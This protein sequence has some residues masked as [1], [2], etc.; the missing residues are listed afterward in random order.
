[1]ISV[2]KLKSGNIASVANMFKFLGNDVEVITTRSQLLKAK[3]IVMPGIGS[4]DETMNYLQ[5]NNLVSI[6]KELIIKHEIPTLGI[7]LG[8]QILCTSSEEGLL[9]EGLSI[10]PNKL[11]KFDKLKSKV[12]HVGWNKINIKNYKEMFLGELNYFYFS[13]SYYLENLDKENVISTSKNGI[14]F[15]SSIINKNVIGVQFH[16]EK[17]HKY[18]F[19]FLDNFAKNF[20]V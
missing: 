6:L 11:K 8:M 19:Y 10:F 12:P 2:L 16:P 15:V 20:Y 18:G 5:E 14:D 13:H 7:C 17:S 1:M 3:K 9:K 4:F